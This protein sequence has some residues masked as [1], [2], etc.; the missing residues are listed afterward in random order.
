MAREIL[1]ILNE[2]PG[3]F[4]ESFRKKGAEALA[5]NEEEILNLIAERADAR[6]SKNFA[7]ADE[8]RDRL[9]AAGISLEDGPEGTTWRVKD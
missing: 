6:K 9:T 3:A 8:I 7:R 5:I 2:E 4:L 1:G